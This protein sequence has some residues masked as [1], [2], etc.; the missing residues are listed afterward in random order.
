MS[1]PSVPP[2]LQEILSLLEGEKRI[3]ATGPWTRVRSCQWS[4]PIEAVLSATATEFIAERTGWHLVVSFSSGDDSVEI[5]PCSSTGITVTFPH[6]LHNGEPEG[7][8][9]WRTGKLCL[10]RPEAA[11][12]RDKWTGEPLDRVQRVI[13]NLD[14]LLLWVDAAATGRLRQAGDPFEVPPP[15]RNI[16]H[17]VIGFDEALSDFEPWMDRDQRWG[18]VY[19]IDIP[20]ARGNRV[21]VSFSDS[22]GVVLKTNDWGAWAGQVKSDQM[23]FWLRLNT[24]PLAGPWGLPTT[25]SELNA[26]IAEQGF[27]LEEMLDVAGMRL[28]KRTYKNKNVT[29]LLG[30]PAEERV[31]DEP[32]RMHW[33]AIGS[34]PLQHLNSKMNGFRRNEANRRMLDRAVAHSKKQL[35]WTRT[36]NWTS[37]QVRRRSPASEKLSSSKVVLLGAGALGG[38]IAENLLRMGNRDLC[39]LDGETLEVGNLTRH[40]LGLEAVGWNKALALADALN[41]SMIDGRATGYATSF[42]PKDTSVI[43]TLRAADMVVDCTGSDDVLHRMANFDWDKEKI[44]VSLAITWRAEGLLAYTASEVG[45]PYFDA[46]ERLASLDTPSPAPSESTMEGIGCWHPIFPATAEDM[47]LWAS[48]GTRIIREALDKPGR[49]LS[50]YRQQDDGQI[51]LVHPNV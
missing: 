3:V 16:S 5:Y 38:A 6:Q 39:I 32:S 7:N 48:F 25:W 14:R 35:N 34:V 31:G 19:F 12:G 9:H 15:S 42:P 11:Y 4:L 30:F 17:P 51:T 44:F 10:S 50:Y 20:N 47:R 33:L 49:K 36:M 22:Q 29:L 2:A 41:S 28:R 23:G 18:S 1:S 21:V 43:A 40:S 46:V 8:D 45:F 27:E 24:I 26:L 37:D 13:W